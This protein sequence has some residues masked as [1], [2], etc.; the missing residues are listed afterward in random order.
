MFDNIKAIYFDLDDTLI[1]IGGTSAQAWEVTCQ[2]LLIAFPE[3][4]LPKAVILDEVIH[5]HAAYLNNPA[6][7]ADF[8]GSVYELRRQILFAAL[9]NL[10]FEKKE[11][12]LEFML[13]QFP[14]NRNEMISL[15]PYV[16]KT[17]GALKQRG[18]KLAL[19]TNGGGEVQMEK[20]QHFNLDPYFDVLWISGDRGYFKP[21]RR[22]FETVSDELGVTL[23]EACMVGDNYS[24][25]VKAPICYGMKAIYFDGHQK[26]LPREVQIKPHC[27]ISSMSELLELF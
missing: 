21:D 22:V 24:W 17:L 12:V 25:E 3:L 5:E 10:E 11:A 18:Y 1:N 9:K 8:T 23:K 27:I 6:R 19:I 26:G 16:H 20:I 7:I 4:D 15:Y 13:T 14:I 2:Q